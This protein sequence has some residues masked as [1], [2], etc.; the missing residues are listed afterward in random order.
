MEQALPLLHPL[1]RINRSSP[2]CTKG[3]ERGARDTLETPVYFGSA[4]PRPPARNTIRERAGER[5]GRETRQRRGPRHAGWDAVDTML[6]PKGGGLRE[7][8]KDM[9]WMP[10]RT[11]ISSIKAH[12]PRAT[13]S[14]RSKV[15]AISPPVTAAMRSM[16]SK[17]A[18]SMDTTPA[19]RVGEGRG[20]GR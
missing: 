11:M 14:G 17:S 13:S 1:N 4:G 7:A 12:S 18:C 20:R 10:A 6:P 5:G 19:W 16:P 8:G 15:D 2:T 3:R 9:R